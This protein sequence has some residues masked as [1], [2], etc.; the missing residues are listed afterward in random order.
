M[1]IKEFLS[2]LTVAVAQVPEAVAFAF[3]AGVD[4]IVGL[5]AA[6]LLGLVT[7][8]LGGRPGMISGATAPTAV[9]M[10]TLVEDEGVEYLFYALLLMGLFQ[11]LI[12]AARLAK[13]A[14]MIPASVMVGFA[15]GLA[16]VIGLA[17]GGS[18]CVSVS[19]SFCLSFSF[20]VSAAVFVSFSLL[21]LSLC[22]L[23]CEYGMHV[24]GVAHV[25]L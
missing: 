1:F 7:S 24:C 9:V 23:L 13:F 11:L 5:H 2:G 25:W 17:Q 3:V 4:P 6:W 18:F 21:L 22:L 14:R 10:T 16:I 12:S 20:S 8:L 19:L 15:N